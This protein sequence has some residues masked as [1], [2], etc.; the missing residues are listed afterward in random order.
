MLKEISIS[1]F[2]VFI[3]A[4]ALSQNNLKT[5][6]L[7]AS[8][9]AIVEIYNANRVSETVKIYLDNGKVVDMTGKLYKNKT[10][11]TTNT[12]IESDDVFVDAK[13]ALSYLCLKK[14]YHV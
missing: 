12:N 7:N 2:L 13:K 11:Y 8:K 4:K 1:L 9:F 3:S 6:N 10:I 5:N 14:C